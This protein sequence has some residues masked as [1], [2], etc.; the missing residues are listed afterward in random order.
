MS[1]PAAVLVSV[2]LLVLSVASYLR[3]EL[4]HSLRFLK[5]FKNEPLPNFQSTI[6]L[7]LGAVLNHPSSCYPYAA[8]SC[9]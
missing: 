9:Y 3:H 4:C 7:L 5:F 6:E 1:R 2:L 8:F